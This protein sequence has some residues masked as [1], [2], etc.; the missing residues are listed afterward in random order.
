MIRTCIRQGGVIPCFRCREPFDEF[1]CSKPGWIEREDVLEV[2]LGGAQTVENS[3][4]SHGQ[5]HPTKPCH[6]VVTNG[7]KATT[8][9][10]SKHR[11]YK[12]KRLERERAGEPKR[13]RD[14]YKKPIQSRNEFQNPNRP[15][16][17]LRS[18]GFQKK[19]KARTV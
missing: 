2:S 6:G 1:D 11:I 17:K 18:Q 12:T 4:Y 15:K 10:S 13:A 14:K 5:R 16:Q 8:A 3:A 19:A 7:T 9:G